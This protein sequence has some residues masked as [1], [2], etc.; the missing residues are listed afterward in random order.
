MRK[1]PVKSSVS[2]YYATV[3]TSGAVLQPTPQARVVSEMDPNLIGVIPRGEK[4]PVWKEMLQHL[5]ISGRLFAHFPGERPCR[6]RVVRVLMPTVFAFL[7]RILLG[8]AAAYGYWGC[9]LEFALD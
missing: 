3:M 6:L 5:P 9:A 1:K 8:G 2:D 4:L 7:S